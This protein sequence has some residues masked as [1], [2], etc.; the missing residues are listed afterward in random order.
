MYQPSHFQITEPALLQALMAEHPLGTWVTQRDGGFTADHIPFL[1]DAG[2]GVL[3]GHVARANP[4]WQAA[5]PSLVVFQ[6]P[7]AYISPS[8]YPGK[9]AHGKVVPTWNYAVVHVHGTARAFDDKPSLLALLQRLTE[10][11]E[12]AQAA[13][14]SVSDAPADYIDQLLGAIV[15]IEIAVQRIE[16]KWKMSQN[17]PAADRAGVVAALQQQGS[18]TACSVA[19]EV[20]A[21]AST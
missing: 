5:G 11:H 6:G 21:R 13:P 3:L 17:R 8:W 19:E 18:D 14:W 15:G 7:Q 20:R 2:R 16:G 4:V 10:T 1:Y 12:R 9:Q